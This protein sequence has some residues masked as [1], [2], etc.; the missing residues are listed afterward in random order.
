M[1]IQQ[2]TTIKSYQILELIG[3]SGM[4]EVYRA[5]HVDLRVD[6][7]IKL[8]RVDEFPPSILRSVVKRFQNEAQK[9]AQLSHPHIAK[10]T[11]YGVY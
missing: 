1:P 4:A 10:V 2:G 5:R 7:A 8:I 11:D 3:R 9:M 6:V